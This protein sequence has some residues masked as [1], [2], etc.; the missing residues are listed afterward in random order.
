[1]AKDFVS[2]L[3]LIYIYQQDLVSYKKAD[4]LLKNLALWTIQKN[5]KKESEII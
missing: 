4:D 1:M 5:L 3:L 2:S